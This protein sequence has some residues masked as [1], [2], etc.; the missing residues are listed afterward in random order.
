MTFR[1]QRFHQGL[2]AVVIGA[3]R[4]LGL[5]FVQALSEASPTVR[6]FAG[7][8][9]PDQSERLQKLASSHQ[10][11]PFHVD[12]TNEDSIRSAAEAVSD[13]NAKVQLL[14]NCAGILHTNDGME[15]ERK[16]SELDPANLQ[17]GF[18]VNAWG[19]V[20]IAKHFQRLL[21]R[22]ERVVLAN[23]SARVGS[24]GDNG[25]GGWYTYRASKAAQNMFTRNLAI[26]L[27]RKYKH[28]CCVALHP[29]T[30][31]TD[32]S[33]PF[34][35]NVSQGQLFSVATSVHK[36]LSVIDNLGSDHNGQFFDYAGESIEW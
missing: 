15:P 33:A 28:L 23:I 31:D 1:F 35:K 7:C 6:V 24:I 29:G 2:D 19:P 36:L 16:L 26:E 21:P 8:R 11:V 34:Q 30:V 32:L 10:V 9:Q 14:I 3:S 25:L 12:L 5:G 18:A 22:R 20:L 27:G 17:R 4:G 13:A